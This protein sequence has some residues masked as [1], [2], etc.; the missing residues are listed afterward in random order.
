MS[1]K[2]PER[3]TSQL[4]RRSQI[5]FNGAIYETTATVKVMKMMVAFAMM[6]GRK[7]R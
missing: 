5:R 1:V 6:P 4:C 7:Y 2:K 3:M